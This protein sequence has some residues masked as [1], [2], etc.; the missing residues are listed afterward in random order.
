MTKQQKIFTG[1]AIAFAIGAII[2]A[3]ATKVA[4]NLHEKANAIVFWLAVALAIGGLI[5]MISYAKY[6]PSLPS[7][8]PSGGGNDGADVGGN[9]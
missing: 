8:Q 9:Q 4:S 3:I 6:L 7:T 5:T 1:G 2:A